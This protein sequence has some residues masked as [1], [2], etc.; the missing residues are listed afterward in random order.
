MIYLLT[1]FGNNLP[2]NE[3][4]DDNFEEIS[5]D[6]SDSDNLIDPCMNDDEFTESSESDEEYEDEM[7]GIKHAKE[8]LYPGAP[9][10]V[11]EHILSVMSLM[12]RFK[13]TGVLFAKILS[14]IHLH[15]IQ[16]NFCIKT[17]YKFQ[18]IFKNIKSPLQ[19]HYYCS[20][21]FTKKE[22]ANVDECEHCQKKTPLS[23]FIGIPII[24]QLE[25]LY[26][27]KGFKELL[28]HRFTRQKNNPH[29]YED[30]YDGSVY[31]EL[32]EQG[33]LSNPDNIS[34]TWNTDGVPLYK[35]SKVSIWPFYFVINELPY[36]HRFKRENMIFAGLWFGATKPVAN[37]FL[38]AFRENLRKL[39]KGL[40]FVLSNAENYVRV[41]G[42][43]EEHVICVQNLIF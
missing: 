13:L 35:S 9:L 18:M 10:T 15:C 30:I 11:A 42:T 24:S 36:T 3:N 22:R 16:P 1:G 14:L 26:K 21:C 19:R 5:T 29:N 41:R 28:D 39:Y 33:F 27:R 12:L 8:P 4:F 6:E 25:K 31:T 17:L 40:N 32:V 20:I 34:L 38:S 37:L 7:L 43:C 23:Y 2:D